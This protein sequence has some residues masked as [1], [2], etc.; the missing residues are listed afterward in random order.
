[1]GTG[2][3]TARG[4][5]SAP[6]RLAPRYPPARFW[7]ALYVD[8]RGARDQ[9]PEDS[10]ALVRPQAAHVGRV[11]TLTATPKPLLVKRE[12]TRFSIRLILDSPDDL[13][14]LERVFSKLASKPGRPRAPALPIP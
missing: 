8:D 6:E 2:D 5:L 14:V 1:M 10:S 4:R 3:A 13:L 11:S 9:L 7:L 12:D